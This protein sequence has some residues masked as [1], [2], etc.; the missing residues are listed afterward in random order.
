[1]IEALCPICKQWHSTTIDGNGR[2]MF[3]CPKVHAMIKF[4]KT[5]TQQLMI[6]GK[7][8]G[9]LEPQNPTLEPRKA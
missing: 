8:R 7:I 9:T 4:S 6:W 2:S 3:T 5:A 1:M